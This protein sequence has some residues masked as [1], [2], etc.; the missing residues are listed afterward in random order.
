[1][2]IGSSAHEEVCTDAAGRG[3]R[4]RPVFEHGPRHCSVQEGVRRVVR[5]GL[6]ERGVRRRG[7]ESQLPVCH[8]KNAEGKE[9][10]KVR[11]AYGKALDKLLDKKEDAKNDEKIQA[12]LEKSPRKNR[13][14]TMPVRPPSASLIAQGKLPS[15][16]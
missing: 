16:N 14:P 10:K 12:A 6:E 1:M 7:Q 15:G 8:G 11:N 4:V 13:T 5:E 9:D 3:L 2:R